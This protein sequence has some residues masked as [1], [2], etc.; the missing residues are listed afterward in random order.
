MFR[1][2]AGQRALLWPSTRTA[3][4]PSFDSCTY[5]PPP[6]VAEYQSAG[7]GSPFFGAPS[8]W[9]YT[10]KLPFDCMIAWAPMWPDVFD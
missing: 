2:V 4:D 8:P 7:V 3:R 6:L 5:P 9:G 1:Q 10:T